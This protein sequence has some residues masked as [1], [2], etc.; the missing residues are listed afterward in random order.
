MA[1]SIS[2]LLSENWRELALADFI[3]GLE[4]K[5]LAD[6]L[7]L[8]Q[9]I[10]GA[11]GGDD[12]KQGYENYLEKMQHLLVLFHLVFKSEELRELARDEPYRSPRSI[13]V[14]NAGGSYVSKKF[15]YAAVPNVFSTADPASP[16]ITFSNPLLFSRDFS[17]QTK[18]NAAGAAWLLHMLAYNYCPP[19]TESER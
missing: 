16:S 12:C 5:P 18:P 3:S 4:S 7:P 11:L 2:H 14:K 8:Q 15:N 19:T 10:L 9:V 13:R 6:G 1:L 17:R